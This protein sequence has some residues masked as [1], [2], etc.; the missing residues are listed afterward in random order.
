MKTKVIEDTKK[1]IEKFRKSGAW[2][3]KARLEFNHSLRLSEHQ[4][5]KAEGIF[6]LCGLLNRLETRIS[7]EILL[8]NLLHS[9]AKHPVVVDLSPNE[10]KHTMYGRAGPNTINLIDVLNEKGF[11][12]IKRGYKM[13]REARK[14]R[15]W[16]TEKLLEYCPEF[17]TAVIYD[18]VQL[19]ILKDA[20]GKLKE[21]KDT[22][23]TYKIRAILKKANAVNGKAD[24]RYREYTLAPFLHAVFRE[25]FTLYGRLHTRG[26][27]HY[28]GFSG[29]ERKEI[30]INGDQTIELD[31]SGLHP[32]L[33]YAK[34]GIQFF[35]D[36]Y[37]IV[38]DRPEARPFLKQILLSMLNN[39][40]ETTAE[41]TGNYW[42]Y[43]NHGERKSLKEIGITRARPS[44]DAFKQAHKPI[45]HHFCNGK[46]TGMRIM[47][48]DAQIAL[49]IIKHFTKQNIPILSIHDSFIVQKRYKNELWQ[50]MHRTYH[51]HTGGFRCPIK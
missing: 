23:K 15:I 29:E 27:R 1:Q 7:F 43:N 38:D 34:Q 44:I 28:Q 22:A 42:L 40:D 49:D 41:K 24:I 51:K 19:V 17:S 5:I 9:R 50:V 16:A 26:Y 46:K 35:G 37:S 3:N 31:F 12:Q 14:S 25:K 39:K 30:T 18:P 36:P 13:E 11:L 47:N 10:W 32:H 8:A 21:Y 2:L 20:D 48:L 6:R 45:A 4:K 33:L